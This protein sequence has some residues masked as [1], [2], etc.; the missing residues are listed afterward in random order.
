MYKM[1]VKDSF[2]KDRYYIGIKIIKLINLQTYSDNNTRCRVRFCAKENPIDV[3][4][5]IAL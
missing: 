2:K 4:D 1:Y 5:N 3:K